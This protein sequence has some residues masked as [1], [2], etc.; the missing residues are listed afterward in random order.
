MLV[1]CIV[2]VRQSSLTWL[3]IVTGINK[4][5]FLS[6]DFAAVLLLVSI[7]II[8]VV[9]AAVVVV[10]VVVVVVSLVSSAATVHSNLWL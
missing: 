5:L 1:E 10:V 3:I 4:Q 9:V 8:V 6:A 2:L 7:V